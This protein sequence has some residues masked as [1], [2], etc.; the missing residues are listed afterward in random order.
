MHS[1]NEIL[2][3]IFRQG[4]IGYFESG[5]TLVEAGVLPRYVYQLRIPIRLKQVVARLLR[6]GG[7][8]GRRRPA[9]H[10]L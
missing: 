9:W 3:S 4:G 10:Q 8:R 6:E 5:G 7:G 2:S 1:R